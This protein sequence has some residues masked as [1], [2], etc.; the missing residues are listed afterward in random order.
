MRRE[1]SDSKKFL[2]KVRNVELFGLSFYYSQY[3][4]VST[5]HY[6]LREKNLPIHKILNFLRTLP[7][8][9][10]LKDNGLWW[11]QEF[12]E[13]NYLDK[14]H[15]DLFHS[16]MNDRRILRLHLFTKTSHYLFYSNCYQQVLYHKLLFEKNIFLLCE[17]L[18]IGFC[19]P[20]NFRLTLQL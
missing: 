12:S 14:N 17:L 16:A 7:S 9:E 19:K 13:L 18:L 10:S 5:R 15:T 20:S 6:L 1:K 2:V 11:F 3:R 4:L 8:N